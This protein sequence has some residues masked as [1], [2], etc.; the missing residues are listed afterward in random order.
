MGPSSRQC[1]AA[2]Q[3]PVRPRRDAR[4]REQRRR[5][6]QHRLPQGLRQRRS[7]PRQQARKDLPAGTGDVLQGTTHF[8]N[9]PPS[10]KA[11]TTGHAIPSP[12]LRVIHTAGRPPRSPAG[13]ARLRRAGTWADRIPVGDRLPEHPL[14]TVGHS[15]P[16]PVAVPGDP[17]GLGLPD[18]GASNEA[19]CLV[20]SVAQRLITKVMR[21][22]T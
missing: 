9:R 20:K 12:V 16:K 7:P 19:P 8:A 13:H 10:P 22:P 4:R 3:G 15:L 6:D 21:H 11:L 1:A 17:S 14:A 5:G 2:A 18:R